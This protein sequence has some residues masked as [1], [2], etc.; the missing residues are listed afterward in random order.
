MAISGQQNINIGN[1]NQQAG[2]DDLY[3]AFNK[4][5]NNFTR[6]FAFS[7]PFNTFNSDGSIGVTS[8]VNSG[9]VTFVNNG[10]TAITAGT[11]ITVSAPN[12]TVVISASG[13]GNVG[14]TNVGVSSSTLDVSNSP[15]VSSGIIT[16]DLPYIPVGPNFAA[17]QYTSPTITVDNYGRITEIANTIGVGTVDSIAIEVDGTGLEISGS[18]I[19]S[20]GTIYIKNTGVTRISAGIG[21][22]ISDNTGE[23]TISSTNQNQGTVS[24]IDFFSNNLTITGS[25]VTTVGNVTIDI[26]NNITISGNVIA[27]IISANTTLASLGNASITGN[28]TA[29]NI[30]ATTFNGNFAG[31]LNGTV[32]ATTPNTGAFTTI[33]AT[34]NITGNLHA[35]SYL[36]F[37]NTAGYYTDFKSQTNVSNSSFYVPNSTGTIQQVLGITQDGATQALGWKTIPAQYLT[38]DPRAGANFQ[39]SSIP[40]LRAYPIAVRS[41]GFL[42]VNIA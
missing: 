23:L 13:N 1:V 28:L 7:S 5:Q 12:G 10:V 30:S 36:R 33:T 34:A 25:P 42:N 3:T 16:V 14:V 15:I 17:G 2:S 39:V 22:D 31:P 8:N 37:S 40:V 29:G 26:P 41:G 27:D 35:S 6:L 11:G 19:T 38:V 4:V 21:I 32:G 18:P 24:R 20:N 9:T